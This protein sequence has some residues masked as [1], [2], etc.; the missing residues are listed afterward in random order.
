METP[1]LDLPLS[2]CFVLGHPMVQRFGKP[3]LGLPGSI[4]VHS[5][6]VLLAVPWDYRLVR[7]C[8]EFTEHKAFGGISAFRVHRGPRWRQLGRM[9]V[10]VCDRA[11]VARAVLCTLPWW[12]DAECETWTLQSETVRA[13]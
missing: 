2:A 10:S 13:R 7:L 12:D 9:G 3:L 5:R 1:A 11:R 4:D 6:G 8:A